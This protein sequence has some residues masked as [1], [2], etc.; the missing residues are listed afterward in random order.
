MFCAVGLGLA[1]ALPALWGPAPSAPHWVRASRFSPPTPP[2]PSPFPRPK[3]KEGTI[4]F[5]SRPLSPAPRPPRP[6]FGG[7]LSAFCRCLPCPRLAAS[8]PLDS[9]FCPHSL[10]CPRRCGPPFP[11]PPAR[12]T[13]IIRIGFSLF[14]TRTPVFP[15]LLVLALGGSPPAPARAASLAVS[16]TL[17]SPG[18]LSGGPADGRAP[19]TS[20]YPLLLLLL[21]PLSHLSP[22]PERGLFGL[23]SFVWLYPFCP[24]PP[25]TRPSFLLSQR[26]AFFLLGI[27]PCTSAPVFSPRRNPL[28][29]GTPMFL[30]AITPAARWPP[31]LVAVFLFGSTISAFLPGLPPRLCSPPL[32]T[33]SVLFPLLCSIRA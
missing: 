31:W 20:S 32:V 13:N 22:P 8:C 27:A 11:P 4:P 12:I 25:P 5:R 26:A 16:C 29:L 19:H 23:P 2:W 15:M 10:S 1:G 21:P 28:S 3:P 24:P 18:G 14:S 9:A 6:H 7:P 17:S 33:I 30:L